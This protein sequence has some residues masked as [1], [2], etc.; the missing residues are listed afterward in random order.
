MPLMRA[1]YITE[2]I[3]N[4]KR[5]FILKYGCSKI[6]A[7]VRVI[8]KQLVKENGVSPD[9]IHVIGSVVDLSRFNPS[10]DRMKFRCEMGFSKNTPVIVNMVMI[11]SDK[12]KKLL[13]KAPQIILQAHPYALLH[14]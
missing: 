1:V 2:P 8:K 13:I 14:V 11:L 7:D 10:R 3:G 12:V 9:K 5:G 4:R 6:M